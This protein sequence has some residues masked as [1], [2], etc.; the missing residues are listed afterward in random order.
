ME[1]RL[2]L[3]T[4]PHVRN[5]ATSSSWVCNI[6]ITGQ[7]MLQIQ[8]CLHILNQESLRIDTRCKWLRPHD[9]M[10]YY[11]NGAA[12]NWTG[13]IAR[14]KGDVKQMSALCVIWSQYGHGRTLF[15]L[16]PITSSEWHA[17]LSDII[18]WHQ[19]YFTSN[20]ISM[21]CFDA[22]L[23]SD[24]SQSDLRHAVSFESAI[25]LSLYKWPVMLLAQYLP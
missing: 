5:N 10:S 3:F 22:F 12:W 21:H 25:M 13:P 16:F 8:H 2:D 1:S 7:K 20:F 4:S 24:I 9:Q 17:D 23:Q 15:T 19:S 6:I 11:A 18:W 14:N